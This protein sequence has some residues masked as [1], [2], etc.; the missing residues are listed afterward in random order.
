MKLIYFTNGGIN[1][2]DKF[3][4][5]LRANLQIT[6]SCTT[7]NPLPGDLGCKANWGQVL[8]KAARRPSAAATIPKPPERLERGPHR[9]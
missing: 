4:H 6:P 8:G 1:G 3:G 5:F 2:F 9:H 7:L